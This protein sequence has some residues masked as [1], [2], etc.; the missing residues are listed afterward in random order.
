MVKKE[1]ILEGLHCANCAAKI[2]TQVKAIPGVQNAYIDFVSQKLTLEINSPGT[3][4]SIIEK[5]STIATSVES[6]I[7]VLENTPKETKKEE[8]EDFKEII[9]LI[10]GIALYAL[11]LILPLSS[12]NEK[13]IFLLSYLLVGTEVLVKALK[14]IL[15]GQVFDENFLMV[16][17]TIGAF[18]IGEF[19]EAVAVMVFYQIGEFFQD[20]AVN[21][22]R[23]NIQAF[24]GYPAGLCSSKT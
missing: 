17:A 14:N 19:P 24:N 23:K 6:G 7:R 5:A 3:I 2:E 11:G 4:A 18:A 9:P 10:L 20:L 15:K 1:L 21:R 8:K 16:I 22:S 13:L 12:L